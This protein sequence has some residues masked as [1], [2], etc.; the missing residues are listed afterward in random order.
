LGGA[1]RQRLRLDPRVRVVSH[2]D[3]LGRR[4]VRPGIVGLTGG[5]GTLGLMP[6]GVAYR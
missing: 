6:S 4:E 2:L 5:G 1:V 3:R